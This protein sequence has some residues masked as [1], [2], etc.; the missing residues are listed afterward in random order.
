MSCRHARDNPEWQRARIMLRGLVWDKYQATTGS[1]R[2]QRHAYETA[3]MRLRR[4][5]KVARLW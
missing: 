1:H 2:F 4:W 5:G 3:C